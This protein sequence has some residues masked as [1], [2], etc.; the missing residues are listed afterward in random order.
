LKDARSIKLIHV[1]LP[2]ACLLILGSCATAPHPSAIV[3]A[4]ELPTEVTMNKNAGRWGLLFVT[5]QSE[6]GEE[7]PFV[8]DT[9]SSWTVLDK[10]LVPS[11]ER[12]GT[13]SVSTWSAA[14]K[15]DVYPA[16]KLY[17]GG[18]RLMI[19]NIVTCDVEKLGCPGSAKGILGMDCLKHYC[20][21]LDFE[22]G[23]IRFLDGNQLNTAELGQAFP[24]T[25]SWNLPFVYRAGFKGGK[26][27]QSL[28]DSGY[29][30]DGRIENR[31]PTGSGSTKLHL[32]ECVWDG[33]SYT[34]VIVRQGK[35]RSVVGLRFL[36]RHLV[37]LDFPNRTMY[38]K[39]RSIGPL[40]EGCIEDAIEFLR[41]LR[42][43]GQLPG[44]SKEDHGSTWANPHSLDTVDVRKNGDS[45]TYH[46]SVRRA[47]N[48]GSWKLQKAWRTDQ[49]GR[50]VEEYLLPEF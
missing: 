50:T 9:G 18:T 28:I 16:P 37:T 22:A 44:S 47:S 39:Q 40:A 41:E 3:R 5:L 20:I 10:S 35:D 27:T 43:K 11:G 34:N 33:K 2:Y 12:L 4:T 49:R 42:D 31:A 25:I 32:R 7:L 23:R 14:H 46:Y 26:D 13:I 21:Q 24:L 38:L 29:D 8:L 1:T 19:S 48:A 17:L 15:A 36:A 30:I 6:R 45:S